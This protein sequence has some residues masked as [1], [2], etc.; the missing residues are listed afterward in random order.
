MFVD[1]D[2]FLRIG[3]KNHQVSSMGFQNITNTLLYIKKRILWL[4]GSSDASEGNL[5]FTKAAV[6]GNR[7]RDCG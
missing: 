1:T 7:L 3:Q 5:I 2:Q 4:K 6:H